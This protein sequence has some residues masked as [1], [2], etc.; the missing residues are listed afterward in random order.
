MAEENQTGLMDLM[1]E[2]PLEKL[3]RTPKQKELGGLLSALGRT[4]AP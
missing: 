2:L 1:R 4:M 3:G